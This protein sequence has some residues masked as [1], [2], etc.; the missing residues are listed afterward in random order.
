MENDFVAAI[1]DGSSIHYVSAADLPNEFNRFTD[2]YAGFESFCKREF[3]WRRPN[4]DMLRFEYDPLTGRKI[5][6]DKVFS[7]NEK[8]V[9]KD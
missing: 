5:D 4:T 8:Y 6:W 2:A 9:R 1:F 7:E 3:S